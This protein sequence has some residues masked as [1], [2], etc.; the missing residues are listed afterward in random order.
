MDHQNTQARQ[1]DQARR[2]PPVSTAWNP[3]YR[4]SQNP[5]GFKNPKNLCYRNSALQLLLHSPLLANWMAYYRDSPDHNCNSKDAC[6]VCLFHHLFFTFRR[7]EQSKDDHE[8][9]LEPVWEKMLIGSWI[10]IDRNQQQDVREFIEKFFRQI[11]N[12][13]D[14]VMHTSHSE[15]HKFLMI[16]TKK[17]FECQT[18]GRNTM[19]LQ[20]DQQFIL[21]AT[22]PDG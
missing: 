3:L 8:K 11:Y 7:G 4:G 16:Q 14:E 20:T 1:G 15:L 5:R 18:C 12:E 13:T 6:F 21:V 22:F 10:D 2:E 17:R 9:A 19:S